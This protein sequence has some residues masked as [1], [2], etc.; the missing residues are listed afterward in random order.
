LGAFLYQQGAKG[1]IF[2]MIVHLMS[3]TA[4]GCVGVKNG[5]ITRIRRDRKKH[6]SETFIRNQ[7][8]DPK[9]GLVYSFM[10]FIIIFQACD[11]RSGG[12]CTQGIG[13]ESGGTYEERDG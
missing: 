6:N 11:S 12:P 3:L 5:S 8:A 2:G 10:I 13:S 4:K 7:K 9:L 1:C